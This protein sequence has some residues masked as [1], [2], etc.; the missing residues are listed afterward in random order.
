[1][2]KI[3]K[4]KQLSTIYQ[5]WETV[6]EN[7][8]IAHPSYDNSTIKRKHYKD[9]VM[10]ALR[11]QKGLCAYTE[12]RLC[13]P[14][15]V[16]PENWENGRYKGEIEGRVHSGELEHFDERLKWK[17]KEGYEQ[18]DWLWSNFFVIES[19][20][21][22]LKSTKA[23]DY[24]LKPDLEGYDPFELMEYSKDL[25]IYRAKANLPEANKKRINDMIKV[26]GL[27]FP[28]LFHR[29][30]KI[31]EQIIKYSLTEEEENEFPT[32][33]EFCKRNQNS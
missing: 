15:Y 2:R 25:H 11:C 8:N 27:N 9:I 31:V 32:A 5:E 3:D 23:V 26:L 20:I 22:N 4:T 13:P 33:V 28:N 16:M 18:K 7:T 10:D 6:L 1:M 29:R 30:K 17:D 14:Q 19:D 12:V 21:N 24:I